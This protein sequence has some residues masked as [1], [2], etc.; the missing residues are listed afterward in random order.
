MFN[1]GQDWITYI[2]VAFFIGFWTYIIIK[3]RKSTEDELQNE[4]TGGKEISS[5]K[6]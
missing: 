4:G 3:G 6:D 2:F 5:K 1:L